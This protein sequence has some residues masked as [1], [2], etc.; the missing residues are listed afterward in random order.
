MLNV[1]CRY[2]AGSTPRVLLAQEGSWGCQVK[3]RGMLV[4]FSW[5]L[6]MLLS[7]VDKTFSFS[8]GLVCLN[9]V[10]ISSM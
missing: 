8:L 1:F 2:L 9:G 10:M 5:L 4:L 7:R 3:E 6:L